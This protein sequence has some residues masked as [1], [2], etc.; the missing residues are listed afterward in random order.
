MK[1]LALL[2]AAASSS[3]FLAN[4]AHEPVTQ[5]N[6]ANARSHEIASDSRAALRDLYASNPEARRL[7]HRA[8]AVL[9]FPKILKGGF[10]IGGEGGN[11]TLF[12]AD[13]SVKGYYQT[14]AAT[15]GLEAG[16][17]KF[18]YALFLTNKAD[19]HKLMTAEGWDVGTAPNVTVVDR[20]A[21]A[22]VTAK[23]GYK[24]SYAF[25]FDQKGLMAGV[26]LKGSKITRIH[27]GQ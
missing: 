12:G 19:V 3:L 21:A 14:A 23:T 4:C 17:Q 26:S 7:G 16:V 22:T 2:S 18:G 15:Y 9:V 5:A 20:G 13:G 8:D 6:A 24:G 25:F 1:S 27:P 11:G 10:V